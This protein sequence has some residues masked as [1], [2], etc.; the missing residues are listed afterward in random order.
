[1]I[2]RVSLADLQ[3]GKARF[4]NFAENG[5]KWNRDDYDHNGFRA[6]YC[7]KLF[8]TR[9]EI[10]YDVLFIYESRGW[11]PHLLLDTYGQARSLKVTSLGCGPSGEL[12][13]LEAYI[14]DL[15][16]RHI[17]GIQSNVLCTKSRKIFNYAT[18]NPKSQVGN[19]YWIR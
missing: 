10:L 13:G 8:V 1:M 3:E 5:F 4:K 11:L 12:A 16:I 7:E 2:Q 9:A 6:I 14:T 17:N 19:T 18:N 15:K